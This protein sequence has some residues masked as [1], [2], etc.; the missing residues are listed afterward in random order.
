M[1][2]WITNF[3]RFLWNMR[4][5]VPVY[6]CTES[7]L[8]KFIYQQQQL[9]WSADRFD[10]VFVAEP[11]RVDPV[12]AKRCEGICERWERIRSTCPVERSFDDEFE[13]CCESKVATAQLIQEILES[14]EQYAKRCGPKC[15]PE[16]IDLRV[17]I[18]DGRHYI[19]ATYPRIN[20]ESLE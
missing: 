5:T 11:K 13:F 9:Q 15:D 14:R 16:T 3:A 20:D 8:S 18:K 17:T 10:D 4:G 12:Y 1:L 19:R 7:E 2:N 6:R